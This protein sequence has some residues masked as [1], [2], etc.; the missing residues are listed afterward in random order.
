MALE[1]SRRFLLFGICCVLALSFCTTC[2]VE[3]QDVKTLSEQILL[4]TAKELGVSGGSL[5]SSP[6][7]SDYYKNDLT[8]T[9]SIFPSEDF[10]NAFWNSPPITED[11]LT[12]PRTPTKFH[13]FPA[14]WEAASY[15]PAL[16]RTD[17]KD[18]CWA[19]ED[20][21]W[22]KGRIIFCIGYENP[23]KTEK[24]DRNIG[25]CLAR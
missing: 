21:E 15:W 22:I 17:R 25:M 6:I 12:R 7:R 9:I 16:S 14:R 3:A 18:P 4:S 13:G 1:L 8:L 5:S 10:A 11:G 19:G 20:F 2:G 24:K 23:P